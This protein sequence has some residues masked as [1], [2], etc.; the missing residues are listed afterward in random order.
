MKNISSYINYNIN[1]RGCVAFWVVGNI[2]GEILPC[3]FT[4]LV[5]LLKMRQN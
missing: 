1:L 4:A 2:Y 5:S 3:K